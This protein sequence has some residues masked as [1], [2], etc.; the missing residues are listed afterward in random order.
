M[1]VTV[2]LGR[3]NLRLDIARDLQYV[4]AK[5]FI[6]IEQRR[7]EHRFCKCHSAI[8]TVPAPPMITL[9]SSYSDE[10]IVDITISKFGEL[11]PIERYS[12]IAGHNGLPNLPTDSLIKASFQLGNFMEGVYPDS[13]LNKYLVF[14]IC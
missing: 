6:V 2:E 1:S 13:Q 3:W 9:G 7:H 14:R 5:E 12:R 11:I 10:M 8:V 4:S